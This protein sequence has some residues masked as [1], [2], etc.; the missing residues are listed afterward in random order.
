MSGHWDDT[1]C[2]ANCL[3][4]AMFVQLCGRCK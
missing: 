4:I 3:Q 2:H 1:I